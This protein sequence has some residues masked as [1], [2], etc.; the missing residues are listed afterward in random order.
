MNILFT[1]ERGFVRDRYFPEGVIERLGKLGHVAYNPTDAPFSPQALTDALVNIDVCITHW[2]CP[3]F[4]RAVLRSANQ[5]RLI[6]HAAGS[7]GDLVSED[8]YKRGI[9]V[10][11]ANRVLAKHVAEG[12]LADFLAGLRLIPQLDRAM[13]HRLP[14]EK[15]TLTALA[16]RSLYGAKIALVG[17]GAIGFYLL[18]L[19]APFEAHIKV[20]DPYLTTDALAGRSHVELCSQ[21]DEVLAW[22]DIVSLHASLTSETRGLIDAQ[23]LALI[24]DGSLFVNTAR[25]AIVDEAALIRELEHG[26][27]NAVL[28]VFETE[29]LST[30]SRLRDLDNV[31]LL[32]HVAGI[33]AA[34]DMSYAMVEEIWRY[35]RGEALH[36]EIVVEKFLLMTRE[37]SEQ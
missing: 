35:S 17:L 30:D 11:S 37:R 12:V 36:H 18:D 20:Y 10:C 28:D 22:G 13:K 2:G 4:T 29:S 1:T 31:I 8:V 26:R 14:D 24:K 27:L 3:T 15:T 21:L 9:K 33:T 16:S 25:G 5:L 34:E 32:P 7:V 19:L 23:K 6:A